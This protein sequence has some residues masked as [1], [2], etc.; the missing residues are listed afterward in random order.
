[1]EMQIKE[2]LIDYE[3]NIFLGNFATVKVEECRE[4]LLCIK[5]LSNIKFECNNDLDSI[6]NVLNHSTGFQNGKYFR[7]SSSTKLDSSFPLKNE[8]YEESILNLPGS[9]KGYQQ[10][11]YKIPLNRKG[12]YTCPICVKNFTSSILKRKHLDVHFGRCFTLCSVCGAMF[13]KTSEFLIHYF[14]HRLKR[15]FTNGLKLKKPPVTKLSYDVQ[16]YLK[17]S[18]NRCKKLTKKL[19]KKGNFKCKDCFRVF[20]YRLLFRKHKCISNRKKSNEC[21]I[22]FKNCRTKFGLSNHLKMHK[23]DTIICN[24]CSKQFLRNN[25][26]KHYRTHIERESQLDTHMQ[27]YKTFFN[28][29]TI[30]S[31]EQPTKKFSSNNYQCNV[32]FREFI[33]KT[34]LNTHMY[35]HMGVKPF[36]CEFCS[37]EFVR[38]D[39]LRNHLK[40]HTNDRKFQCDICQRRFVRRITL[41][42]HYRIHTG[43]K[44]FKCEVCSKTFTQKS[45][46]KSHA[47]THVLDKPFT[48]EICSKQFVIQFQLKRHLLIHN[49]K[50]RFE[51]EICFKQFNEKRNLNAHTLLHTGTKPFKCEVCSKAFT[52]KH[53][54][55]RHMMVHEEDAFQ[56]DICQEKFSRY[57]IL[58]NHYRLHTGE[59]PF[60]CHICSKQFKQKINLT[61]HM[62]NHP[63]EDSITKVTI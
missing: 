46:L 54:L 30:C 14:I 27:C 18:E 13:G 31:I 44:P 24:I 36:M 42:E 60:K 20:S 1:M 34:H 22:C 28:P 2:E 38:I 48:C 5:T 25:F 62:L 52:W 16:N 4:N 21:N 19:F 50:K 37:K 58:Q 45:Q 53:N 55:N 23:L 32:C 57:H 17:F 9:S 56:C 29:V 12:K 35:D 26:Y 11:D 7:N 43:E 6:S 8:V 47:K 41:I 49:V 15:Q 10:Q 51:C 40:M 33:S 61:T 39:S 3:E 63:N 59:V